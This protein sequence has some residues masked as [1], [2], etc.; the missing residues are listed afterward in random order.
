M[1]ETIGSLDLVTCDAGDIYDETI[2]ALSEAV[3]EPLYPGDERRMFA[4]ALVALLNS[5]RNIVE[6]AA[7]QTALKYA[8]G[9]VL[10]ALGERLDVHRLG[11]TAATVVLKFTLSGI[12]NVSTAI[13]KWTKATADGVVYFATD[14]EAEIPAGGLSVEVPSTCTDA[15]EMGNGYLPG[16]VSTLVDKIPYIQGVEN[17][18]QSDGG[19]DGEL[20]DE[21]GDDHFR[22]RI[23]LAVSALSVAGP[24][25]AYEYYAKSADA[26]ITDVAVISETEEFEREYDV[27]D[28]RVYIGG[29]L[30][31]P[32]SGM[33]VDGKDTGF[34]YTYENSLLTITITDGEAKAKPSVNVR[35]THKMDGRVRIVPLME[36]GEDPSDEVLGRILEACSARDVRPMTDVVTVD[37][38]TR[39]PYD[40]ELV[41]WTAPE[42][43]TAV[44]RMVE[45]EGG[46][47]E[48]FVA[49]QDS[50]L[51][52]DINPDMLLAYIMK[53]PWDPSLAD[54]V[55]AII[56]SPEYTPVGAGEAAKFSGSI[57]VS[58]R[59]ESRARWGA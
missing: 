53:H 8:R 40:I 42:T 17:T 12:R 18:T 52:R 54:P 29:D 32:D 19:S 7:S 10:D 6:D 41:Y 37:R 5:E 56:A 14:D 21:E 2:L 24:E 25:K 43:E 22:E 36:D 57:T 16:T 38:P 30:L 28:G 3:G 50:V 31:V 4:E 45:G 49:D 35:L 11:G 51:G 58:H 44:V 34:S 23:R 48:R 27:I 26:A 39:K 15:G 55:R 47:I 9:E 13:P 20:Y 33:T 1:A 59:L 46:A